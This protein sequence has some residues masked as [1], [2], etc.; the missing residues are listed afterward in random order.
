M[1]YS[2]DFTPDPNGPIVVQTEW[3]DVD[4]RFECVSLLVT[5]HSG[6]R[7]IT[8]TL[9]RRMPVARV[10]DDERRDRIAGWDRVHAHVAH[11]YGSDP[12]ADAHVER[13]KAMY[14]KGGRPRY[15]DD[16]WEHV[17]KVYR[18]SFAAG[19]NPTKSVADTFTVSRSAAAKWVA[20]CRDY[21]LL[22]RTEQRK[23]G[24]I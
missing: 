13:V 14:E 22:G 18:D 5:S 12:S 8:A 6:R 4:G 1:R 10:I 11:T 23:P 3:D 17:A 19:D 24:G 15:P 2:E 7:P 9:V 21:G 20:R 16:H